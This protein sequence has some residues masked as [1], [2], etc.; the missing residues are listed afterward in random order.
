MMISSLTNLFYP[1]FYF[2]L[3]KPKTQNQECWISSE[4][5]WSKILLLLLRNC[6]FD[7]IQVWIW[8]PLRFNY[9]QRKVCVTVWVWYLQ[10]G[11]DQKRKKWKRSQKSTCRS[12]ESEVCALQWHVVPFGLPHLM[13]EVLRGCFWGEKNPI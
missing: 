10:L 5:W 6:W 4:I 2:N 1:L 3:E 9:N 8:R 12:L 11:I 13:A 7:L